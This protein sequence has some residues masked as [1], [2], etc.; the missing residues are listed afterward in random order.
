MAL[1]SSGVLN[2]YT[3]AEGADRSIRYEVSG[4][5]AAPYL[6]TKACTDKVP[7]PA[8]L[9]EKFSDF[10]G[11]IQ[12]YFTVANMSI[13]PTYRAF[14]GGACYTSVSLS[15]TYDITNVAS[16]SKT[17]TIYW[18][19]WNHGSKAATG[20]FSKVVA[21]STTLY[22]QS[23]SIG[24]TNIYLENCGGGDPQSGYASVTFYRDAAHTNNFG[25]S[26]SIQVER[27][28]L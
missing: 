21:G 7:G 11:H 3:T 22:N 1:Q 6:F 19:V 13:S 8:V 9:P 12:W 16:T 18:V 2:L 17:H 10:Y 28:P 20:S 15:L 25:T 23:L 14:F 26:D 27:N 5:V 4:S 24:F